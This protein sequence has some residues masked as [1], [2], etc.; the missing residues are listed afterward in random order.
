M[1]AARTKAVLTTVAFLLASAATPTVMPPVSAERILCQNE[2]LVFGTVYGGHSHD[3]RLHAA[4]SSCWGRGVVGVNVFVDETVPPWRENLSGDTIQIAIRTHNDLPSSAD[5]EAVRWDN[6]VPG[7][8]GLPGTGEAVTD[9]NAG[10]LVGTEFAFALARRD[11]RGKGIPEPY[12]AAAYSMKDEA[13]VRAEWPK[14][15]CRKWR[16]VSP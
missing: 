7:M 5:P 12:F 4:G 2:T 1:T 9:R 8:L 10:K 15:T 6:S 13:W 14:E 16:Q 3:C 11:A